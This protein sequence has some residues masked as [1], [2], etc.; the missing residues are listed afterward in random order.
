MCNVKTWNIIAA[1]A[2]SWD[3]ACSVEA[4]F[5]PAERKIA[6]TLHGSLESVIP[7]RPLCAASLAGTVFQCIW[8][9]PV[10]SQMPIQSCKTILTWFNLVLSV[11][12]MKAHRWLPSGGEQG[13]DSSVHVALLMLVFNLHFL[14]SKMQK[15]QSHEH[16]GYPGLAAGSQQ[17]A[18]SLSATAKNVAA[19][20]FGFQLWGLGLMRALAFPLATHL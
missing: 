7:S 8:M 17:L 5:L 19:F 16:S 18:V 12:N 2:R 9:Y 1:K 10:T 15:F 11:P 4:R 3:N 20:S 6:S 13:W 14:K